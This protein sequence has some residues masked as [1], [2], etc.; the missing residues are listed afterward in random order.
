MTCDR[1]AFIKAGEVIETR[2]VQ[3]FEQDR[4]SV[5]V[6]AENISEETLNGLRAWAFDVERHD[7]HLHLK[8]R[9]ADAAPLVLQYLVE[10][11]ARVFEFT[12]QR[13]SLEDRFLE[14]VGIDQGL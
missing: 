2:D 5:L 11:G 4:N 3:S 8:L 7:T 14:L 13:L 12:P 6:R 1:V 9:S 10:R